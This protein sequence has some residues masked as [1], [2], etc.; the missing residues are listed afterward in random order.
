MSQ[1][2]PPGSYGQL[3]GQPPP[4]YAPTRP[5]PYSAAAIAGFVLSLLGCL[6]VTA[7]LGLIFGIVGIVTTRGRARRGF[8][9]AVA[10]LPISLVMGLGSVIGVLGIYAFGQVM[11]VVAMLP[12]LY[13]VNGNVVAETVAVFRGACTEEFQTEVSETQ[14]AA[15][16]QTA[17]AEYGSLVELKKID[18]PKKVPGTN[19]MTIRMT[20]KFVSGEHDIVVSLR[21]SRMGAIAIDDIE[22]AGSSPRSIEVTGSPPATPE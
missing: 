21:T 15:W 13:D 1:M 9:L 3:P 17:R 4:G 12:S 10:A 8:G 16:F 7:V 2:P 19:R 6:G 18:Q 11:T 14:L 22:V 20:G 5:P